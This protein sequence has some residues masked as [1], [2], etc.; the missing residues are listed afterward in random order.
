MARGFRR[1]A[2]GA[3]GRPR[4]Q[5]RAVASWLHGRL[6]RP[7][8]EIALAVVVGVAAFV[9]SAAAGAAARSHLPAVLFGL[10][11][12]AAVLAVARFAGVLYALP[13]GVVTILAF[14]WYFLPPLRKLDAATVLLLGVFPVAPGEEVA[15]P[16]GRRR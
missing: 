15:V 7:A 3:A 12:L 8:L 1:A 6:G 5:L 9:L 16:P 4:R 13:V 11:L 10:L 14:D 2:A